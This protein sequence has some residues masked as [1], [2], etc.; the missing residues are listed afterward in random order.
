MLCTCE[1]DL[2]LFYNSYL[3]ITFSSLSDEVFMEIM[4]DLFV[5]TLLK[6][7]SPKLETVKNGLGTKKWDYVQTEIVSYVNSEI[8]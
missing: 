8:L 1:M 4:H 5:L 2:L 3:S 7:I 6:D